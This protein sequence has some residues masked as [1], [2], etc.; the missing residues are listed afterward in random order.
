MKKERSLSDAFLED[1]QHLT[2]GLSATLDALEKDD[3]PGAVRLAD[4]LDR[5]AGPHIEFEEEVFYP[6]VAKSRGPDYV[7]Q[8]HREHDSGRVAINRLLGNRTR[9][10]LEPEERTRIVAGL[11]EALDHAV[12]CGTLLSHVTTLDPARQQE[13]LEQLLSYRRKGHRWTDRPPY[14]VGGGS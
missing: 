13:V 3:L 7:A 6:E 4:E 12:S 5:R 2:R 8:L 14:K 9:E 11:H 10:R 1:H